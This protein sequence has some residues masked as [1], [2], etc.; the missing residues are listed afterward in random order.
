M[1]LGLLITGLLGALG[2]GVVLLPDSLTG[3]GSYA[4][5]P[6]A[7]IAALKLAD[8]GPSSAPA[9]P[10]APSTS[11]AARRPAVAP[12]ATRARITPRPKPKPTTKPTPSRTPAKR[13]TA[14]ATGLTGQENEVIRLVNVER[15]KAGCGSVTLNTGAS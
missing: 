13:V 11:P 8:G 9:A 5:T 12:A 3:T 6:T 7:A 10:A 4:E 1:K 14:A 15:G 2:A